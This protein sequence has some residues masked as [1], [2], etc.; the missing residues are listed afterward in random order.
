PQQSYQ[1]PTL[2]SKPN[3]FYAVFNLCLCSPS[4][5][6]NSDFAPFMLLQLLNT[7]RIVHCLH[8]NLVNV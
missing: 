4:A 7:D 2:F 5:A 6:T 1:V 3:S 8:S